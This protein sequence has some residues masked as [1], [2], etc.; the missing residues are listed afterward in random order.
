MS[1]SSVSHEFESL[2]T[3]LAPGGPKETVE[4]NI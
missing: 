4:K 1:A 2:T 3:N